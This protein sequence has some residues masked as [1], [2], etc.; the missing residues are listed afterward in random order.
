MNNGDKAVRVRP[1]VL[2]AGLDLGAFYASTTLAL[3]LRFRGNVPT[4]HI[5]AYL[6]AWPLLLVCRSVLAYAFGLYDFKHKLTSAD[7]GFSAVGAAFASVMAG[8]VILAVLQLYYLP[9]ARLSRSAPAI[10]FVLLTLW[11]T[12]S[13]AAVLGWLRFRGYRVH[14]LL[15]GMIDACRALAEELKRHAPLLVDVVGICALEADAAGED[16]LGHLDDVERCVGNR[17]IDQA[18]LVEVNLPQGELHGLLA[19]CDRIADEIYLF[20]GLN[21]PIL[22]NTTVS[23][24]GG[25]PLIP[26]HPA[27]QESVYRFIKR[28]LDIGIAAAGLLLSA[29]LSLA[30]AVAIKLTSPGPILF[31][32][33]RAGLHGRP[34]QILK[35]RTMVIGAEQETGPM[36]AMEHDPRVTPVGRWLRQWRI[37]E[38]PQ[39]WNVLRGEMSVVGPRPERQEFAAV[40][41]KEN[42]LYERRLLVKPGLT[43]IAQVH[44]RYDSD[45]AHKLR[46]DLIYVNSVSLATD[47]RLMLATIRTVLTGRGAR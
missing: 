47:L 23:S 33:E 39:L 1:E 3:F 41:M 9:S 24:I 40:F 2:L 11:F 34:F 43:G 22:A 15:I 13:R 27:F 20:P 21:L 14:L 5:L 7:H 45:Y 32:Q 8:Y 17:R 44:G 18:I 42:P 10:D 36:L 38:I 31:S 6:Y 35:F 29:P 4:E 28:G 16:I 19:A 25:I 12:V 30:A 46:Y 26:L 37:D